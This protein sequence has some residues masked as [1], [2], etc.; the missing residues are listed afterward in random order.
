MCPQLLIEFELALEMIPKVMLPLLLSVRSV[1]LLAFIAQGM[2]CAVARVSPNRRME[3]ALV[4]EVG[5]GIDGL[6]ETTQGGAK[7]RGQW[8]RSCLIVVLLAV[9]GGCGS[10][11]QRV[12]MEQLLVSDAVDQAIGKIDFTPLGGKTVFLD[13]EYLRTVRPLGF[14]NADYVI[15]AL[16]HQLVASGC[17]LK[18]R[19]EDAEIIVEPRVGSLGTDDYNIVYGLPRTE[20]AAIL[21]AATNSGLALPAIPELA[22]GKSEYRQGFAKVTV[23]AYRADDRQAVWQSGVAKSTSTSRDTWIMGAGPFQKGT[24]YGN[25]L[26]GFQRLAGAWTISKKADPP[27]AYLQ[28]KV[29]G[30]PGDLVDE[31]PIMLAYLPSEM[32]SSTPDAT[33]PNPTFANPPTSAGNGES[34][35]SPAPAT[36]APS[37][38]VPTAP[39]A[40][41][42][43]SGG[44]PA[45]EVTQP[46]DSG[47][48]KPKVDSP[49]SAP[50]QPVRQAS[51]QPGVNPG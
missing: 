34:P 26:S 4:A 1:R 7:F 38:G 9:W 17:Y 24:I 2:A 43:Q 45:S 13:P 28:A 6:W 23:F 14:V 36:G 15:S 44:M 10:M 42:G 40:D 8:I 51:A 21:G 18:D 29:F 31:T 5:T 48:T 19:R 20:A 11:A 22:I 30:M 41:T 32:G 35:S 25:R 47:T 37:T 46:T 33:P 27:P 49:V 39:A 50:L 12:A 3:R 16:R